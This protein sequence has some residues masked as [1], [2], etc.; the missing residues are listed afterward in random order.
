MSANSTPLN[1]MKRFSKHLDTVIAN[2]EPD[3]TGIT[4]PRLISMKFRQ[5]IK[6]HGE[7]HQVVAKDCG[8]SD[9]TYY[10]YLQKHRVSCQYD[11]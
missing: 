9:K 10:R 2:R 6:Q 5:S 8:V 4:M 11:K 7:A 1:Y 3:L